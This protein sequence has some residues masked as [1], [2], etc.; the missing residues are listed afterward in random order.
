MLS[1][2]LKMLVGDR[3]KYTGLIFGITFTSFLV[4]FAASFLS[5]FM[6]RPCGRRK[7]G[8]RG[9]AEERQARRHA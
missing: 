4:T 1:L 7:R 9:Q 3:A 5:G 8:R 6:T 2:A